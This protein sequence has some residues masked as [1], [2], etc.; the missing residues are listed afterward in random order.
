MALSP[1]TLGCESS[2]SSSFCWETS[3]DSVGGVLAPNVRMGTSCTALFAAVKIR[4]FPGSRGS[5]SG[6]GRDEQD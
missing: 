1:S 6:I 3:V 4:N 2:V 5:G